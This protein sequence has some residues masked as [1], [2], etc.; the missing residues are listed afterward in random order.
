MLQY[1]NGY[2]VRIIIA[3][4]WENN[5]NEIKELENR[6]I[7]K[8]WSIIIS[9]LMSYQFGIQFHDSIATESQGIGS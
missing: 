8:I 6:I 2:N 1:S 5:S 9:S 3:E 7:A 4:N